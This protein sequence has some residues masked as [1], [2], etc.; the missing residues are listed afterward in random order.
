MP[1]TFAGGHGVNTQDLDIPKRLSFVSGTSQPKDIEE[2]GYAGVK[3]PEHVPIGALP[4]GGEDGVIQT[5]YPFMQEYLNCSGSQVT[6]ASQ[7]VV[8]PWSF[9]VFYGILFDCRPIFGYRRRPYMMIG[10]AVCFIMLLVMAIMPIG[11]PY[12]TDAADRSVDPSDYTPDLEARINYDAPSEGAKYVMLMFFAAVGYVMADVSADSITVELAQRE[13]LEKRGKM[14]SCIYTVRTAMVIVGEFL[15]GFFFNGEDYGGTFNFSL[16]FPQLMIVVAVLML[17]VFPTTWFYIKE[18]KTEAANFKEYISS[19]WDLL[20]TRAVYQVIAYN[21]FSHIFADITYTGSSPVQKYMVGVTPINNTVSNIL[22]NLLFAVGIMVTS[23]WGLHWNWRWMI[24]FT[25]AVVIIVDCTIT[26]IV[27][28]DVFR[29]QWF[30]L[31]PP[32]AVQ[33]PAGV[34]WI[35]STFVTVELAGLGNEAA[36]C[37]LITTVSNVASPFASAITLVINAPFDITNKRIQG[38]DHSIRMDLTYTIIIM[39]AMT[40]FA[41]AFLFLLPK[42]KEETQRLLRKGGKSK[43]IGAITVFYLSFA[44]VWS[45]M[46]NIMAIFDSTAC[47]VIAGG[48]G[49]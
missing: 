38:D 5:I 48:N 16:S 27:I 20:S 34:G 13:P 29:N 11:K 39:Y 8:L 2:G 17:P 43:L 4:S 12:F 18:E 28:W 25:G 32:I 42:Q 23:K 10:W 49:C 9:K 36:V 7:L 15:T 26:M 46:T 22:S 3:T 35:I 40:V 45:V 37:G 41:W 14:Q 6:A 21:F 44:I 24:V 47:L 1:T 33:L 19:F 31:G 30:W